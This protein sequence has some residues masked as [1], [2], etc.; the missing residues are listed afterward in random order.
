MI[1][2]IDY[3]LRNYLLYKIKYDSVVFLKAITRLIFSGIILIS[4][5]ILEILL[6]KNYDI[7]PNICPTCDG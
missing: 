6:A 2:V 1:V 7:S 3:V 4:S 5:Y